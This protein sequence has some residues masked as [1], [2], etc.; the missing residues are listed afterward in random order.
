MTDAIQPHRSALVLSGALAKGAFEAGACAALAEAGVPI[1]RV[2]GSSSGALNAVYYA[3]AIRAGKER[4]ATEELAQFW[5]EDAEWRNFIE[6]SLRDLARGR[7]LSRSHKLEE[8]IRSHVVAYLPGARRGVDLRIV[9]TDLEGIDSWGVGLTITTTHESVIAYRGLDFEYPERVAEMAHVAAA[10]AAVPGIFSPV[11]VRDRECVDG[12]IVNNTPI[13]QALEDPEI[14]RVFVVHPSPSV[15]DAQHLSGCRLA[16]HIIDIL[17]TERLGRDLAEA[18]EVNRE[19]AA[20]ERLAGTNGFGEL[21]LR[22]IK[23]AVG[24]R[25]AR[26]VEIVLIEPEVALAGNPLTA[27]RD[28]GLRREYVERGRGAAR[29]AVAALAGGQS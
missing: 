15:T 7:G 25:Y 13:R 26:P 21:Q 19:L 24:L 14:A 17:I 23:E 2:V 6:L 11:R 3:A 10:S 22:Q 1:T 16:A 5:A 12:G 29:R 4:D 27:L 9:L 8:L 20:I 18:A 28:R